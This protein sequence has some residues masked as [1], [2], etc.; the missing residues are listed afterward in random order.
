MSAE[1]IPDI[2]QLNYS[3]VPEFAA[4]ALELFDRFRCGAGMP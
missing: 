4:L 3:A 1:D 2:L